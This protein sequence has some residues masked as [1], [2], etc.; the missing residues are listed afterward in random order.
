MSNLNQ[1]ERLATHYTTV[2]SLYDDVTDTWFVYLDPKRAT[3]E[4]CRWKSAGHTLSD[5]M[6][7]AVDA[8]RT[9]PH[10]SDA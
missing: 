3:A 10:A 4:T 6:F 5:A 1:Y 8:S 2:A 7:A 9:S